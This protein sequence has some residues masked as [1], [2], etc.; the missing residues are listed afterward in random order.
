[1]K[2]R[3]PLFIFCIQMI[4][5]ADS[6]PTNVSMEMGTGNREIKISDYDEITFVGSAD[7]EYEQSDKRLIYP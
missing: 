6:Q 7:F 1:M 5:F 3:V 4:A 2:T